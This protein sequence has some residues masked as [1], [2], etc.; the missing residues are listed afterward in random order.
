M[1][2]RLFFPVAPKIKTKQAPDIM[3]VYKLE[4]KQE[5]KNTTL[6][7]T[8]SAKENISASTYFGVLTVEFHMFFSTSLYG[9]RS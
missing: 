9:P 4:K 8:M 7:C 3:N 1:L 5:L 6:P 2:L